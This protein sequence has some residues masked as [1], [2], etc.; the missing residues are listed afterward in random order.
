MCKTTRTCLFTLAAFTFAMTAQADT[1]D[2]TDWTSAD[3][4]TATGTVAGVTVS[5]AGPQSPPS[6]TAGGTNYWTA[7]SAIYRSPGDGVDNGSE[8]NSS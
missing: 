6:Q 7:N 1:I 5:F 4:T 2:W 3:E 8:A